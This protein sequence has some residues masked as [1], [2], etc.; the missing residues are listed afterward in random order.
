MNVEGRIGGD[1]D[2]S[3][4]G[5]QVRLYDNPEMSCLMTKPAK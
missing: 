3:P 4:R 5:V 2:L 1:S